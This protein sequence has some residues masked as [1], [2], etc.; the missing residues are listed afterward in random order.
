MCSAEINNMLNA[1]FKKAFFSSVKD[2]LAYVQ[3]I[4]RSIQT[5][6]LFHSIDLS[7][8]SCWVYLYWMDQVRSIHI[9][10]NQWKIKILA[11]SIYTHI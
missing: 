7:P 4:L 3:F 9:Q 10:Y 8:T 6:D 2:A 5:K 1:S 11:K